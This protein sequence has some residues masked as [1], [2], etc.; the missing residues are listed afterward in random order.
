MFSFCVALYEALVG[1]PPFTGDSLDE[2]AGRV[3]RGE[4]RPRPRKLTA[5]AWLLAV[6]E[7][8]LHPDP[9]ARWPS[10]DELLRALRDDPKVRRRRWLGRAGVVLAL[11]GGLAGARLL[12]RAE[13]QPA[14][15]SAIARQLAGTWDATR[16]A[17]ARAAAG[18]LRLPF[19]AEMSAR[20]ERALDG[21]ARRWVEEATEVCEARALPGSQP[22]PWIDA[23]ARCLEG[24]R[25]AL[26]SLADELVVADA[27]TLEHAARAAFGLPPVERC[28][29]I[30][31][32]TTSAPLPDEPRRA[33]AVE[34]VRAR[35]LRTTVTIQ[36]GQYARALEQAEALMAE[37]EALEF[38]PLAPEVRVVLARAQSYAQRRRDAAASVERAFFEAEATGRQALARQ[39]ASEIGM[40]APGTDTAL[41]RE[42][43]GRVAEAKLRFH[44]TP[45]ERAQH[46]YAMSISL[47]TGGELEQALEHAARARELAEQLD[48]ETTTVI[49]ALLSAGHAEL[50]LGR[51]E[52]SRASFERAGA[53]EDEVYGELFPQRANSLILLAQV[54]AS[55]GEFA[56]ERATLE[57]ALEV[58]D[59]NPGVTARWRF[60]VEM[61]LGGAYE[62]LNE[63]EQ[64]RAH[65][66]RSLELGEELYGPD[67]AQL[68]PT[69]G[70][71]GG[72]EASRGEL[73]TA[74]AHL[75]HAI[76][77][78]EGTYGAEHRTTLALSNNLGDVLVLAGEFEEAETLMR[79]VV[80]RFE[81]AHSPDHADLAIMLNLLTQAVRERGRPRE[82]LELAER[83]LDV[84][85]RALGEEDEIAATSRRQIALALLAMSRPAEAR[86][87]AERALELTRDDSPL[88]RAASAFVLARALA[89]GS[90][91]DRARALPLA[92]EGLGLLQAAVS[93]HECALRDDIT[94]WVAARE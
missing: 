50:L 34:A 33:A 56:A 89:R 73:A 15:C 87:H 27:T 79:D 77:L 65:L 9:A 71:L 66:E 94:R 12:G 58:L 30:E 1:D 45:R 32:V 25:V 20:V 88:A 48:G 22:A 21:Y 63:F 76:E 70:V 67:S 17:D 44:S 92:R 19:A 23:R 5:P 35:L 90:A 82:A 68:A 49:A 36:T 41:D 3:T 52:A 91:D 81:R 86:R 29:D 6:V 40:Y 85:R 61:L 16:R 53:L 75:R 54:Q 69:L 60:Q 2:L 64:A 7:R 80:A 31:Y 26:E 51:F 4:R 57:R 55:L 39:C 62:A 93:A 8:G 18:A 13:V 84:R 28:A 42:L 37:T 72:L 24:R 83:A 78:A 47:T 43:W 59:A 38:P 14:P 10:M 74:R 11:G 46:H